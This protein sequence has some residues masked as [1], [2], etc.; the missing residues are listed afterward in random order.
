MM[1]RVIVAAL[2]CLAG[3]SGCAGTIPDLTQARGP[4]IDRPG[5]WCDFTR[6]LAADSYAYAEMATN[7]YCDDARDFTLPPGYVEVRR[8]PSQELCRLERRADAGD[9]AAR[10][11]LKAERAAWKAAH[12]DAPPQHGFAYVVYDRKDAASALVE[13]IIAF[14]GTDGFDFADWIHGNFGKTQ[15]AMGQKL[16]EDE[17]ARLKADGQAGVPVRV[18]GHSLGGA[19]ALQV[20]VSNPGVDA[21]VFN[22]S[23]NYDFEPGLPNNRRVAVIERGEFLQEFRKRK[24]PARQEL[25]VLSCNPAKNAISAHSIR[26][27]AECLIW[28]AARETAGAKEALK[29]NAITEPPQGEIANQRWGLDPEPEPL[30]DPQG[31]ADAA[32][33]E[34][35]KAAITGKSAK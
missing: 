10:S 2:V 22:P 6:K 18:T 17:L 29:L 1:V 30:P 26:R 20:S 11:Q 16:Y 21:Y 14:R 24:M 23:P 25:L 31:E 34:A 15:L 5:G 7:A 27:L 4:C 35:L 12:P 28:I 33:A 3:L 32:K 19:I 9:K 8:E 13:R